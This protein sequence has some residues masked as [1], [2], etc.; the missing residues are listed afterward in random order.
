MKYDIEE[1]EKM[2]EEL[3]DAAENECNELGEW[4]AALAGLMPRVIDGATPHFL[5]VYSEELKLEHM[6]MKDDTSDDV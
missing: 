3:S 6:R 4:W 2:A 5:A 1:M